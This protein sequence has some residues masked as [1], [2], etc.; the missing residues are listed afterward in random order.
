MNRIQNPLAGIP[1]HTLFRQVEEFANLKG[2]NDL[3][4]MLKKGALVAQD[5][6][7]Y[8]DITGEETLDDREIEALRN[9]VLH[10]WRQPFA[11]YFTI[12]TCSIGKTCHLGP[13]DGMHSSDV[14]HY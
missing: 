14:F 2:L 9:E 8:E 10:K 3:I 1:K 11:L 7:N 5:P 4:P 6:A 12:I 13:L